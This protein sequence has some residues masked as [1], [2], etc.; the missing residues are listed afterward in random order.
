MVEHHGFLNDEGNR[1]M[2][3]REQ[4]IARAK[5]KEH[6]RLAL[7]SIARHGYYVFDELITEEAGSL[8]FLAVGPLGV[9]VIPV[10]H[11]EG[12]I[13]RGRAEGE[14]LINGKTFEDDPFR[15][16]REL[17]KELDMALFEGVG[18]ISSIVCF[19]RARFETD[20]ERK[21]PL[22]TTPVW[23][24]P[25]ALDPEGQEEKLNPI[26][27]DEIAERVQEVYGRPP[28][29]TPERE[30]REGRPA[31]ESASPTGRRYAASTAVWSLPL[32]HHQ[33]KTAR[34]SGASTER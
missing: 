11:D 22:G 18:D 15:Q 3:A 16:A 7:G 23:E 6:V 30:D 14:I 34:F 10:R 8:D 5:D 13:S 26:D 17:S 24:L 19:T 25:W 12:Y 21:P 4:R 1:P 2:T 27:T 32:P 20:D 33:P 9:I 28:I 31:K 29:V